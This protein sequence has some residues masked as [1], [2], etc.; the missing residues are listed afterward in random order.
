MPDAFAMSRLGG[1]HRRIC[2]RRL[3][4]HAESISPES[5]ST[6]ASASCTR[7]VRC[8]LLV[9]GAQTSD[10]A[11][12]YLLVQTVGSS[13]PLRA[14][15]DVLAPPKQAH[16]CLKF[17]ITMAVATIAMPKPRRS[18]IWRCKVGTVL[19]VFWW[20][21]PVQMPKPRSSGP[22]GVRYK[23]YK[24]YPRSESLLGKRVF[25]LARSRHH[26]RRT[27]QLRPADRLASPRLAR[28]DSEEVEEL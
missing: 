13:R 23:L 7:R 26:R 11:Q 28:V 22:V 21:R 5:I 24:V 20:G 14:S 12:S 1:R 10:L 2:Q 25:V 27:S 8:G 15:W 4:A 17:G 6:R 18:E 19:G 3:R 9:P 16:E